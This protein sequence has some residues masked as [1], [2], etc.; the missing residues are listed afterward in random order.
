MAGIVIQK[1]K[2]TKKK[3]AAV[4]AARKGGHSSKKF[5]NLGIRKNTDKKG[6]E[7][8]QKNWHVQGS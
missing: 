2:T 7:T 8:G 1:V 4:Q 6:G 3:N 5:R